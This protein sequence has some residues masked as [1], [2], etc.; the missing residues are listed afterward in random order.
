MRKRLITG[1]K[2]CVMGMATAGIGCAGANCVY[3][4]EN[5]ET[6]KMQVFYENG[7]RSCNE[8]KNLQEMIDEKTGAYKDEISYEV[9][10]YN[11]FK[12]EE[13]EEG[14]EILQENQLEIDELNYP[15]ILVNGYI[16]QG[17]EEIE[18]MLPAAYQAVG[19][20]QAI[21]FYREDCDECNRVKPYMEDLPE[22]ILY[23]GKEISFHL[24]RLNSREG[25]NGTLIREM[26]E[27]YKVPE[28]DQMVPFVFLTDTYL[29]GEDAI[30][31]NLEKELANGSGMNLKIK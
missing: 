12:T 18:E 22:T 17:D 4:E 6:V 25:E 23:D 7:C 26:F 1:I 29:A 9:T 10:F 27:K 28:E 2:L 30:T 13:R 20:S 24:I 11:M 15:V 8:Q 31:E 5:N 21:Y 19:E 14:N 3:A 16:R